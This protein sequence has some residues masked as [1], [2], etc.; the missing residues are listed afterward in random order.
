MALVQQWHSVLYSLLFSCFTYY[1]VVSHT[2][3]G[4]CASLWIVLLVSVRVNELADQK[5]LESDEFPNPLQRTPVRPTSHQTLNVNDDAFGIVTDDR[6]I[7]A[8]IRNL[9][10]TIPSSNLD[11][12]HNELHCRGSILLGEMVERNLNKLFAI[13]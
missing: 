6:E 10:M 3:H 5:T 8:R 13:V 2:A 1:F 7:V 9:I 12:V 4:V 11:I